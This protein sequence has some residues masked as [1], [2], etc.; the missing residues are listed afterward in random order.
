MP[1]F[2]SFIHTAKKTGLTTAYGSSFDTSKF[3]LLNLNDAASG[4]F[5]SPNKPGDSFQ[6]N[7]QLFRLRGLASGGLTNGGKITVKGTWDAAGQQLIIAPTTIT[8]T[9][10]MQDVDGTGYHSTTMLTDAYVANATD[11]LYI[12]IKTSTGTFTLD[13]VEMTWV[14]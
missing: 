3:V 4:S 1:K 7:L 8:L 12:W 9:A 6:G 10:D 2:G 14:E 13:Q 11:T 5:A